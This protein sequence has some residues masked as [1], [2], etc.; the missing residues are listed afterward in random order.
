M[1]DRPFL[2]AVDGLAGSG[3]S[4]L[5]RALAHE[6][7]AAIVEMDD[8]S[9]WNG[10]LWAP[11][12]IA[13]VRRE[14]IDPLLGGQEARYQRYNWE[15]RELGEWRAVPAT[16]T[17]IIEG[18]RTLHIALADAYDLRLWVDA[19]DELRLRRGLARDGQATLPVWQHWMAGEEDYLRV[20][21]PISRADA[22][23]DGRDPVDR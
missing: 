11:A 7:G 14:V 5:A 23:I 20:Q 10:E 9:S 4:T 2:I 17:V 19:P 6:M 13:R 3:K 8:F 12:D 22:V 18:V 16:G 1:S 15:R 21:D